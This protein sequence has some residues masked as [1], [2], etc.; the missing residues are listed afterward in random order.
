MLYDQYDNAG[1]TDVTSQNFEATN[2][3]FDTE[4]ADDFVVPAGQAWNV[5]QADVDGENTGP[6]ASVN[7][8]IYQD[9]A[10]LPGAQVYSA[11]GAAANAGP[12]AGDFE[13]PLPSPP[14]LPAG[15]Y[16]LSVQTNQDFNPNGQWYWHTRTVQANKRSGNV[17]ARSIRRASNG[18][19]TRSITRKSPSLPCSKLPTRSSR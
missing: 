15:H 13:I 3:A 11:L 2:D 5:T 9:A 19:A 1:A 6:A 8:R 18:V 10:G 7:V 14:T 17:A 12:A 16:W 4:A